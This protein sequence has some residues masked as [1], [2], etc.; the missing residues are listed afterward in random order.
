MEM[1]VAKAQM[2]SVA[3]LSIIALKSFTEQAKK[4]EKNLSKFFFKKFSIFYSKSGS[5]VKNGNGPSAAELCP[6]NS[7]TKMIFKMAC[8]RP[9]VAF[10]K[11]KG[12]FTLPM[13]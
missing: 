6:K 10:S 9:K 2:N 12:S 4:Y 13:F 3:I 7:M 5:Q 11:V 8:N 1:T